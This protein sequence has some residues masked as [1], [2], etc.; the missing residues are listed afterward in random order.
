MKESVLAVVYKPSMNC[1]EHL[2]G[3]REVE[4]GDIA[5]GNRLAP[6]NRYRKDGRKMA[7]HKGHHW[8]FEIHHP[9]KKKSGKKE[10]NLGN[11]K[12]NARW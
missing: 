8:A 7:D 12:R 10:Y 6:R 1:L 11:R 2:H 9:E 4:K 3:W 5:R